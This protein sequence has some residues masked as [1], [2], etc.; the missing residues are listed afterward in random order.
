MRALTANA[1]AAVES[2]V[3]RPCDVIRVIRSLD[4][5]TSVR[6]LI[7]ALNGLLA[8]N[9]DLSMVWRGEKYAGIRL[10]LVEDMETGEQWIEYESD[11]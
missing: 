4:G 3:T 1:L 6:G 7:A 10:D 2:D 5:I 11:P 9:T 8:D